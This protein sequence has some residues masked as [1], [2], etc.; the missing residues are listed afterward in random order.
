MFI[1]ESKFKNKSQ[2]L[3][4]EMDLRSHLR[5]WVISVV[6]LFSL[7]ICVMVAEMV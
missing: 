5:D 1:T 2:L 7:W 3:I 4:A 6:K